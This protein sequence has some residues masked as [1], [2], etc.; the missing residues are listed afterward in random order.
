M[1]R[2]FF[3]TYIVGSTALFLAPL[4][5]SAMVSITEV[6]YDLAEGGDSGREWVEVQ[7]TGTGPVTLTAWKFFEGEVNHGLTLS[8]GSETI[9]ASGVGIIADNPA[10]FLVDHPGF[11][12]TIFDSSFSLSNTG[13]T[14]TLR[15]ENLAD[16]DTVSYTSEQGGA[17]DGNS[18]QKTGGSWRGATPTPGTVSGA[19]TPPEEPAQ[20]SE[21]KVVT[22]PTT[23]ATEQTPT[24]TSQGSGVRTT[25]P[26]EPQVFADA[27][28]AAR[29]GIAGADLVFEG[30]AWGV[31]KN[32]PIQSARMLWTF[33]DGSSKEGNLV[34]HR[35]LYPGI[36]TV[37][38]ETTAGYFSGTDRVEVK[39]VPA[40][41]A[42]VRVK[43]G[44]QGFIEIAN[45]GNEEIDLSYWMLRTGDRTA[46]LPRNTFVGPRRTIVFSEESTTLSVPVVGDVVL[47]YP[48]GT[49]AVLY[50]SARGQSVVPFVA[51]APVKNTS[52]A[53]ATLPSINTP[54]RTLASTSM[55]SAALDVP[56]PE[57]LGASLLSTVGTSNGTAPLWPWLVAVVV[58]ALGTIGTAFHIR[59]NEPALLEA[60]ALSADDFEILEA[61]DEE[62]GR[63][64][65]NPI[66]F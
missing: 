29:I 41:L 66:P 65:S 33:G 40:E 57:G 11:S 1:R 12:G 13:E 19:P 53:G 27:G 52:T 46:V 23:P 45:R 56:L 10:N 35:F 20:E 31:N 39:V 21:A 15:D 18:L 47:L 6:M 58:L 60:P 4:F 26:E 62:S 30:R 22:T 59:R 49:L 32:E 63:K 3:Y 5:A 25:W 24:P 8:Q 7:N 44:P 16:A 64:D 34:T 43:S 37:V 9:P 38:L 50:D 2:N 61:E 28:P 36:Y 14:L 51:L 55:V 42:I 17:G 48:N 54:S